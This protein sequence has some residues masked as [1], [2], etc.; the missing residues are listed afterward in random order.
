MASKPDPEYGGRVHFKIEMYSDFLRS[1][2]A[3]PCASAIDQSGTFGR[4]SELSALPSLTPAGARLFKHV[5][6][7]QAQRLWNR[8][9][10]RFSRSE[11]DHQLKVG[12]LDD[13]LIRTAL[14]P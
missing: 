12:R 4:G 6:R 2:G 9:T 7:A 5:I 13:W 8:D 1:L 3:S 11:I 10:K 14:R